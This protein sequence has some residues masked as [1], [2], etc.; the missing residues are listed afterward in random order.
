[1]SNKLKKKPKQAP[2]T[3][4]G[5]IYTL[6]RKLNARLETISD[7]DHK[8]LT[9]KNNILS[10]VFEIAALILAYYLAREQSVPFFEFRFSLCATAACVISSGY[11]IFLACRQIRKLN[12]ARKANIAII[13]LHSMIACTCAV[14]CI[15]MATKQY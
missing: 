12:Y 4:N 11:S 9:R 1:M 2:F 7:R 8:A 13:V 14:L 5:G 10:I 15:I 6:E 3:K